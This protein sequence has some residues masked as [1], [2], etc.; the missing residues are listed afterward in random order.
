MSRRGRGAPTGPT[1]VEKRTAF[2]PPARLAEREP[3]L[4]RVRRP[5]AT[6]FGTVLVVLRVIA[7]VIWLVSLAAQWDEVVEHELDIA[8]EGRPEAA[9]VDAG[10]TLVLVVGAIILVVQ[11]ALAVLIWFGSNGARITVM[12]FSTANITI[13]ALDSITGDVEVT[14][15]TTFLTVAL[16]ILILLALSSR[17]ARSFARRT[18]GFAR[19]RRVAPP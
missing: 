1:S 8:I 4:E 6:A 16:D 7:G 19:P 12:L 5:A 15:K 14:I 17:E 13:A 9:A 18:R 3:P 2:E 10:L 11:L